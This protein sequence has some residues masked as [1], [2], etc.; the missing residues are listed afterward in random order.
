MFFQMEINMKENLR[1]IQDLEKEL[2]IIV[3]EENM[4]ILMKKLEKKLSCL[5]LVCVVLAGAAVLVLAY[6]GCCVAAGVLYSHVAFPGTSVL[7]MDVSRMST[8]QVEKL[9]VEQGDALL[10]GMTFTRADLW[11]VQQAIASLKAQLASEQ[12]AAAGGTKKKAK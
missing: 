7:G 9:W 1:I 12:A 5:L 11:R 8:Q 4:V 10:D 6:A 3:V 2:F